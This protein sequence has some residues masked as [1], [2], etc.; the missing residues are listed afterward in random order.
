VVVGAAAGRP[1]AG[2]GGFDG[3]VRAPP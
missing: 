2:G 1:P 3:A